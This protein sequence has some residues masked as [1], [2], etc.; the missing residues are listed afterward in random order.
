M[1]VRSLITSFQD[2]FIDIMPSSAKGAPQKLIKVSSYSSFWNENLARL[3]QWLSV[4]L[5]V[6]VV[7]DRIHSQLQNVSS[8]KK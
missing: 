5:S 8:Y 6:S 2:N 3:E 7:T 4:K 1:P